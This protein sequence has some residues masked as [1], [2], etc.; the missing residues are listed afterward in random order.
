[1]RAMPVTATAV[2]ALLLLTACGGD[3]G[4]GADSGGDSKSTGR[5]AAPCTIGQVRVEA[6]AASVAPVDG[7]TGEVPVTVLNQGD[8]CVLPG[9]PQVFLAG[10]GDSER[11]DVPLV[12]GAKPRDVTLARDGT[13]SFVVTYVRGP[14]FDPGDLHFGLSPETAT[15][16]VSWTYGRIAATEDGEHQVSVSTYQQT[17]D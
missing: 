17:G 10:A 9:T 2:A 16:K 4:E 11:T 7:D 13:A 8:P 14:S 6:G 1:M 15:E 5:A 3:S 12:E